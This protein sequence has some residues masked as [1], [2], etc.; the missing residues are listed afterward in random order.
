MKKFSVCLLFIVCFSLILIVGCGK[1]KSSDKTVLKIATVLPTDHPSSKALE[2]FRD[3]ISEISGG[4]IQVQIFLNSQLGKQVESIELC[5]A[6]NI[7][8]VFVSTAPLTQF[9]PELNALS[10]PFIFRDNIHAYQVV[11]G[12]VG[13]SLAEKLEKINLR[14]L[15]FFDAGSRNIMT[16]KGPVTG[17]DDIRGMKI[18]VMGAPLM[19]DTVNALGASAISMSQG[20]VYTALQ[21]GVIDGWENNPPTALSF[22]M[23]ETGCIHYAHTEH[24]MI[25]DT[26]IISKNFYDQ[27]EPLAKS[28]VE[29]AAKKTVHQQRQ[30]WQQS[31]QQ[32]IDQLKAAGMVFNSVDKTAFK[33]RVEPVYKRY[34]KKFGTEFKEICE[35]IKAIQ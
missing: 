8:M 9:I 27:L 22:K 14:S 2:F 5:Q 26:L 28:W 33:A 1:T 32:T 18:R 20:E 29:Q 17:P 25:P 4:K 19:I 35:K 21:T 15:G 30:L 11:D 12:D 34:Y 31:E 24:L 23:Y 13:K 7:E 10:M 3:T 16:K 6:G